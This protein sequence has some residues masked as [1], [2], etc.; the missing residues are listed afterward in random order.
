M[1]S[2]ADCDSN[3]ITGACPDLPTNVDVCMHSYT[4]TYSNESDAN[5][6]ALLAYLRPSE[7]EHLG[8]AG[9]EFQLG[10]WLSRLRVSVL[11]IK[12][13]S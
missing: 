12:N 1:T 5:N 7:S 6:A 13:S 11:K 8:S 2:F 9:F 4:I 3:L 10:H